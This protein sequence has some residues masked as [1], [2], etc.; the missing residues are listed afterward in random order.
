MTVLGDG[1]VQDSKTVSGGAITITS[2]STVQVGLGYGAT[3]QSMRFEG[4]SRD[5]SSQGKAT[6]INRCVFRFDQTGEGVLYGPTD[7]TADMQ[8]HRITAGTLLNGDIESVSW[9][10]GIQQKDAGARV[11]LKHN[12]PTPCTLIGVFPLQE[13]YDR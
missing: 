4:G 10:G 9:H 13:T 2:A 8:E 11:T 5:G 7:T 3:Y 6:R 1:I 12:K